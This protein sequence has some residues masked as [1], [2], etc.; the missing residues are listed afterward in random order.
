MRQRTTILVVSLLGACASWAQQLPQLSQY[1]SNDYLYDPAVAGSRPLFEIRTAHRYQWVGIQDAPRTFML[2]ATTPV[3]RRLGLGGFLFT[4]N[5]GPTRRS[6]FQVTF[7]YHLPITDQLKLSLSLSGGLVQFL[8]DGGKVT[9]HDPN[10][11]VL[12]DQLRGEVLPDATF[13]FLLYHPKYWFGFT[14]P[15][16]LH[17]KVYFFDDQDG[18]LSTLARHYYAMGGYNWDL[19]EDMRLEPS[20][21]LKYV[22]PVPPKVDVNLLLRYREMVW[23]GGSW[24]SNDAIALMV[25]C[26]LKRTFQFGYS[27]DITTTGLSRYSG[28]TH[29]VMLGITFGKERPAPQVTPTAVQPAD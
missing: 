17:N 23:I 29:E 18:S 16:L 3:G 10:E 21:L 13:A 15:Q 1:R 22:S 8:V 26:W 6:G 25:G 5:V 24:R 11:P 4:D 19:G 14:A 2:S 28:A 7:A 27:Y 12:D 9:F 20:F